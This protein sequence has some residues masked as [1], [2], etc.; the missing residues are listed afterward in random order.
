MKKH[1]FLLGLLCLCLAAL[2]CGC[3]Q[4]PVLPETPVIPSPEPAE[5]EIPAQ[6]DAPEEPDP[7][8]PDAPDAPEEDPVLTRARAILADMTEEQKLGQVFFA[9][10]PAGDAAAFLAEYPL[11][12]YLLFRRDLQDAQG[13]WLTRE[14]FLAQMEADRQ[15]AE[16]PMFFGTDEEG[17][18]VCRVSQ[19]P[20]L[21][22]K[23]FASPQKLFRQGG[24]DAVRQDAADKS[25]ALLALGIN[26]NFAPVADVSTQK[27]DF[28]YDRAFGRDAQATADYVTAVV[29]EMERA[30]MGSVLKHFPGYGSN[31][32][33]HTAAVTDRRTREQLDECDLVPFAAGIRAGATAVL[34]SHNIVECM[35]ASLPASLSPEVHRV[36]REELGFDGLILTDDLAMDAVKDY[37]ENGSAAVLALQAGND[38]VVTSDPA[39]DIAAVRQALEQGELT[40]E[41]VETACLRVLQAKLRLGLLPMEPQ[42]KNA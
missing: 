11:G 38:M 28:I 29:E 23:R 34:V 2:L 37:T 21:F 26:I 9:R 10:R 5:P 12:G 6:P 1:R 24:L 42:E 3:G 33:T 40:W 22:A 41:L 7:A 8:L 20:E 15:A 25:A 18:T 27:D 31:G 36:L 17:G 32:D 16:I 19:N 35:D 4:Q 14:A 13:N 39:G 30:G